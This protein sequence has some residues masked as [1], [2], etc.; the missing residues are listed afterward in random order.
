MLESRLFL[1]TPLTRVVYVR[2]GADL[3][4]W[5]FMRGCSNGNLTFFPLF[6]WGSSSAEQG[7]IL[8]EEPGGSESSSLA[9]H[10]EELGRQGVCNRCPIYN[11][12]RAWSLQPASHECPLMKFRTLHKPAF[13]ASK[14]R[15]LR[16]H[17]QMPQTSLTQRRGSRAGLWQSKSKQIKES[18]RNTTHGSVISRINCLS[19]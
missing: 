7:G 13:L 19:A 14:T 3:Q 9:M 12:S 15:V 10:G 5:Q 4:M 8:R 17:W 6:L 1:H 2:I 11:Q 18:A 16:I